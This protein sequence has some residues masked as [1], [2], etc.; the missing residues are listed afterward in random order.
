M[1]WT[2][3][4]FSCSHQLARETETAL[5][6]L[7]A[8]AVTFGE[9]ADAAPQFQLE[10]GDLPQW[11]QVQLT[12]LFDSRQDFGRITRALRRR[13]P[14]L[15][16]T[17][18]DLEALPEQDWE[19]AWM[20]QF[21]PIHFG[22]D[23]WICPTSCAPPDPAATNIMLDPGLAFGTGTHATTALC[24]RWLAQHR[25]DGQ[26]VLDYGCGSGILAIT[27]LK[28]GAR[29]ATG[30]DIDPRALTASRENALKNAV[31]DRL[32]TCLHGELRKDFR[33]DLLFANI[34]A[35][36]L[37]ELKP[38]LLS[39]LAPGATIVL[40]GVLRDQAQQVCAA[41]RPE[42]DLQ[43]ETLDDWALLYSVA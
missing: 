27:A 26:I 1:T 28:L 39:R 10:P 5:E 9:G 15:A 32:D 18:M 33:A 4:Q 7:G 42:I 24:M 3:L 31:S 43:V 14:Q 38:L 36:T 8:T 40:S 19:R 12:A 29:Q 21:K 23:L 22:H 6:E 13:F 25:A 35:N 16:D 2:N 41:F 37:I 11:E 17:P 34:L 30:V 20:E